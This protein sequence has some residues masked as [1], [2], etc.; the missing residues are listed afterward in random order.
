MTTD[1]GAHTPSS[2]IFLSEILKHSVKDAT[3]RQ[4]GKLS[5]AIVRL[6]GNDYPLLTAFVARVGS[7]TIF[8]PITDV[9]EIDNDQIILATARLDVRPF[10]RRQGEVLLSADVLGHRLIDVVQAEFVRAHDIRLTNTSEG[11]TVTGLDVRKPHWWGGH[12]DHDRYPTRDWRSFEALIGHQPSLLVRSPLGRIRRLKAAEIADLLEDA[13]ANE[14]TELLAQVHDDPELEADVFEELDDDRQ[15]Q[16][17]KGRSAEEVAAVLSRMRADDAADAIA[18]L[19]QD[20]RQAVLG[21]LPEPQRSRIL[22]LLGYNTATAGGLMGL[23]FLALNEQET[24][25]HAISLVQA[26]TGQ[27]PEALT[28]IGAISLV[29]ALQQDPRVVL[30]D[31]ATGDPIYATAENDIIDITTRM[32]DFNL[33]TLPVLDDNNHILGIITVDDALEAAIPDDWRRRG[34]QSRAEVPNETNLDPAGE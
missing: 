21:A 30:R 3:G 6:R 7:G 10:E 19:P 1:T 24:I 32:A 23:E 20:R 29:Q 11:W 8:V 17:F 25:G 2:P 22:T 33:L 12:T 5:D 18:D 4:L 14:Q 16:L 31:V 9:L 34:K 15:T 28:T 27:Q 13:S 26:A